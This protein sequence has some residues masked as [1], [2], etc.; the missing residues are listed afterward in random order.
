MHIG[1][2][3]SAFFCRILLRY[4]P[5]FS[6]ITGEMLFSWA[7]SEKLCRWQKDNAWEPTW[8]PVTFWHT[9]CQFKNLTFPDKFLL[10]PIHMQKGWEW[11]FK[12]ICSNTHL[13]HDIENGSE[14]CHI[15]YSYQ[16]SRELTEKINWFTI[17]C[18]S[19]QIYGTPAAALPYVDL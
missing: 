18:I 12:S 8:F 17:E 3:L 14:A 11:G 4:E 6:D 9:G 2:S 5:L 1:E 7:E 10:P 16:K 13:L 19:L 15:I